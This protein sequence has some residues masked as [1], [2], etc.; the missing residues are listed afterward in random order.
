MQNTES[1]TA[2]AY[3]TAEEKHLLRQFRELTPDERRKVLA[4][5]RKLAEAQK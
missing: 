5:A 1:T 4:I 2:R 3:I